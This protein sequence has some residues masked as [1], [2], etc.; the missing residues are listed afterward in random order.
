MM[1]IPQVLDEVIK[2]H[3]NW[4]GLSIGSLTA[5]WLAYVLSE[6]DHRMCKVEPWA[7]KRLETLSALFSEV[8]DEKD[9]TDDRLAAILRFLNDDTVWEEVETRLGQRLIRAYALKVDHVRLDS[10]AAAVYHDPERGTLFRHGHSKDHRPDLPQFKVM[11]G[12]LDPMG[13]PTATLVIPGNRDD[14]GLYIPAIKRAAPVVGQGGRLY[15]GDS[16]MAA[17]RIR[18]FVQDRGDHYLVP[19]PQKGKTPDLLAALL[20]PVWNGQQALELVYAPQNE[21]DEGAKARL[22]CLGYE[23]SRSQVDMVGGRLTMWDER[24]LVIY[25][26][27]HARRSRRGLAQR[28]ERAEQ[29]LRALTPPP[30]RGRRQWDD[31]EALQRE[32]KAILKRRRVE[33]LLEVTYR[34]E[35]QRRQVRK[36]GDR[37]ARTEERIRYVVQVK[38]NQAAIREARWLMGWRMYS[39]TAP[40]ERLP[41]RQAML[42]YRGAHR[43]KLPATEGTPFGHSALVC[44]TGR[45]YLWVGPSA[46]AGPAGTD[47]GG[48]CG[49]RTTASRRSP[50]ARFVCRQPSTTDDSSD[51]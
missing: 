41:L 48:A 24:L 47:S 12:A 29:A 1:G 7:A 49:A 2:P 19:L 31:Q 4:Q 40:Q 15:I 18:A 45:P 50:V 26:P 28:L 42:V 17:L 13:M 44:A 32:V 11:L 37:P 27:A 16:K 14:D 21:A 5:I 36:Y 9:F 22:L 34:Q 20:E 46:F 43:S 35:V 51:D 8:V 6:A 10:T 25:S 3:G 33:G 39:I 23:T 30:G 38:R